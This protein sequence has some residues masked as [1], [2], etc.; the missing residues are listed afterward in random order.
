MYV[1]NTTKRLGCLRMTDYGSKF[2]RWWIPKY[3][4]LFISYDE[5]LYSNNIVEEEDYLGIRLPFKN[6]EEGIYLEN[7]LTK[8]PKYAK[9]IDLEEEGSCS[10]C[11]YN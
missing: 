9:E 8:Y 1:R 5:S 7:G 2:S 4:N 10:N 6:K 11:F 3:A